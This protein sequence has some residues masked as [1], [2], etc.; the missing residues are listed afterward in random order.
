MVNEYLFASPI[1]KLKSAEKIVLKK[2]N[3]LGSLR[4]FLFKHKRT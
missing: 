1:T 2:F 3:E 4:A